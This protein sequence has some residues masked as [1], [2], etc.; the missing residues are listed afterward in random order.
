[1]TASW[2]RY[3]GRLDVEIALALVVGIGAFLL[4]ALISRAAR[5][6]VPALLLGL[7]FIAGVLAVARFGGIVYAVPV[8]LVTLQAY[9]WYFLPPYR[10]LDVET[11]GVLGVSIVTS[12]LVA[13]IASHAGRRAEVSEEARGLLANEQAALRRVAT[14][15]ARG[16][17][18][19]DVF[20]AVAEEV[21]RLM[22][23]DG[24]RIIRYES[25][26]SATVVAAWAGAVET[27]VLLVGARVTLEGENVT[28]LVSRTGRSARMDSYAN[29][30]GSIA[31]QLDEAGIRSS[32]GAPIVVEGR[33]WGV[34]VAGS[35]QPEPLP[36][37]TEARLA[38]FT[39]LVATAIANAE[40]RSELAASRARVVAASDETRRQIERDLHDGTQ[41]RLVSLGLGLRAAEANVPP[42]LD[43]LRLVL[44]HTANGLAAAAEDLQEI[45]RGIHPAILSQGGLVPA[46]E[47]LAGRAALPVELDAV[48]PMGLP[49]S[50]EVAAY[51]VAS[52]ALTNAAKHAQASAVE[53]EL[54]AEN[55]VVELA[56][57]DD[58]VGGADPARGSGL[59]GLRDRV[60]ALGGT[61][62]F[63][64]SPGNG[65]SVMARIPT[66]GI[67]PSS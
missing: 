6:H 59:I 38:E 60:E 33:L 32:V 36:V 1:V 58:G 56:I 49:D 40:S 26:G 20:A 17:P 19:T 2:N 41:Q 66:D 53:I 5:S 25:D 29:A 8:G 9:D 22:S 55:S 42:E 44:S 65:T 4:A 47:T 45:S 28:A 48:L 54:S 43:Q 12:V 46:L 31:T 23:I 13:E 35:A 52:E 10:D 67:D 63:A 24:T 57:R 15:V 21:G 39:E 64:S 30:P 14:L 50:V 16:L 18:A 3:R 27:S 62:E 34:M 51:Y 61:I 11:A 7:F 37:R